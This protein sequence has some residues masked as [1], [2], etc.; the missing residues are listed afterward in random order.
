MELPK[1][2][3]RDEIREG[4]MVPELMKRAWG[5]ELEVLQ[6]VADICERHSIPWFADSGT[7]LGAVRHRGFIPWDDD[8]DISLKRPDYNRL[9]ALLP[10]ELPEGFC[11]SGMYAEDRRLQRAAFVPHSRVMADEEYWEFEDYMRR[12]HGFP[13]FRIGIDIFPLDYMP[14]DP[15]MPE[16]QKMILEKIWVLLLKWEKDEDYPVA[17]CE[18]QLCE[19]EELCAVSLKRDDIANQLW[20][21]YD[22]V[23]A[24]GREEESDRI[25]MYHFW[26][27]KPELIFKKEWFEKSIPLPF[28]NGSMP[29]PVGYEGVLEKWYG[30]YR[31][32]VRGSADHSYPFYA[33]QQEEL[34]KM[35]RKKGITRS[36][37]EF[38]RGVMEMEEG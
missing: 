6:V 4:F 36:I 23:S 20:R 38:C 32:P 35:F 30:D 10:A 1:E 28:E 29:A 2:F 25:T 33:G 13:F 9:I 26:I 37:T 8:I 31:I 7:L 17:A 27:D 16:L 24:L 5:A 15:E 11:L 18:E 34:E 12:F 14:G 3:F 19:V 21:L 22:A